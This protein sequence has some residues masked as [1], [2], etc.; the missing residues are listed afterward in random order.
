MLAAMA[1]LSTMDA[2]V[3]WLLLRD[4]PVF[5]VIA[6]RGWIITTAML[7]LIAIKYDL[8]I[9]RTAK[10]RQHLLRAATGFLAPLLFF[11]SLKYLPLADATAIFFCGIFFMTAGSAW[12]L[13]ESVGKHR[14]IAVFVGFVGVLLIARPGV[15][16][17]QPASLLPVAGAASYALLMLWGRKLAE[18]ESTFNILFYFNVV[19]TVIGSLGLPL[20]WHAMDAS[21]FLVLLLVSALAL[22]GYY[23]ITR[24]FTIAS[25]AVIAPLEYTSLVWAL[26]LGYLLWGDF[27]D[28]MAWVGI[29]VIVASGLYILYREKLAVDQR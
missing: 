1:T 4:I 26:L 28:A 18:T 10:L 19:F 7:L 29:A 21:E 23:L 2:G 17:F 16:V 11:L 3:K 25:I 20:I 13:S 15:G 6:V 27:P 24:A 14:W 22:L 9:L 8:L 5:Q 12:L